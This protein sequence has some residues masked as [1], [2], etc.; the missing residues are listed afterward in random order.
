MYS[1]L[2]HVNVQIKLCFGV[3]DPSIPRLTREEIE[4]YIKARLTLL[5]QDRDITVA[6][7]R[8]I[9]AV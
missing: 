7:I 2:Q 3:G 6:E 1:R 8:H 9:A 4:A 5:R